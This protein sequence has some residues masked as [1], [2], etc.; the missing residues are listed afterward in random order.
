MSNNIQPLITYLSKYIDISKDEI[1]FL[2]KITITKKF[3]KKEIIH[4]QGD[5]QKYMAF[6]IKGAIR[7]YFT[8]KNG[9]EDTFEFSFENVIIG[10]YKSLITQEKA[11]AS[12]QAIEN[13][14]LLLITKQHLLDFLSS[15]PK[16]YL[17]MSEVMSDSLNIYIERNR[18]SKIKSSKERYAELCKIQ[19]KVVEKVP[20]NYIAS[21]LNINPSTL[22]RIRAGK[23]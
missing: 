16:Y 21:Y 6:T 1:D 14:T 18:L 5:V 23:V 13:T 19:P 8:D 7:Y 3:K 10:Q 22:S 9:E 17:V 11:P 4:Q 12:A 20:I 2:E 15:F